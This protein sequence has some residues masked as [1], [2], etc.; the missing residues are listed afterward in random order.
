MTIDVKTVKASQKIAD[1]ME[2]WTPERM[3]AAKP[4]SRKPSSR[5]RKAMKDANPNDKGGTDPST[6]KP[7]K[8]PA[9]SLGVAPE[10]LLRSQPVPNPQQYPWRCVGKLFF[11]MNG[12]DYDG[13]ASA[14]GK[15]VLLTVAH[16]LYDDEH[17]Y[18]AE[19]IIFVPAYTEEEE[20]FGRWI[21]DS[22]TVPQAWVDGQGEAYDYGTIT[23]RKGG[24]HNQSI[25][26][27]VGYLGYITQL[28]TDQ[29]WTDVGYPA[30]I[31]G[32]ELMIEDTGPFTRTL[33]Q[34][35][36]VGKEDDMT[37]GA[38]GGPWLLEYELSMRINGV[39]SF[40]DDSFPGEAF[41]PYFGEDVADFLHD[42][43]S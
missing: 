39:H 31:S 6:R 20:P 11:T 33:D 2:Y 19:N 26:D 10:E 32:G 17:G 36:V 42:T 24:E 7:H 40:G 35:T 12:I 34:N 3:K 30:N 4:M 5:M 29:E 27:V 1:I 16:N 43:T 15:N 8:A 9:G 14:F 28:A 25:G 22:Y 23:L 41:S 21:Y 37:E 38:S 18:H 13:S